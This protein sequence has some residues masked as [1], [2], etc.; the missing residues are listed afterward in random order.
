[1]THA[2][3]NLIFRAAEMPRLSCFTC[4]NGIRLIEAEPAG[5]Q[6]YELR[7]YDC[8]DCYDCDVREQFVVEL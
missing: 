6:G 7:T 1:M 8:Y 4:G 3:P 2:F 5:T